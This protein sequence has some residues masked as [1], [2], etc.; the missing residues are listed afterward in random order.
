RAA[1]GC[2]LDDESACRGAALP[3]NGRPR[4]PSLNYGVGTNAPATDVTAVA[5]RSDLARLRPLLIAP[6]R[7]PMSTVTPQDEFL[8]WADEAFRNDPYP[9]YARLQR[10]HPV[11]RTGDGTYV[12]SR[13]DDVAQFMKDPVMSIVDPPTVTSKPWEPLGSTIL[14][15]DPPHHTSLR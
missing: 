8:P 1:D 7:P 15:A 3:E 6:R 12:V 10:R 14:F 13:Y 9:W 4:P 11:Y 2:R 5:A